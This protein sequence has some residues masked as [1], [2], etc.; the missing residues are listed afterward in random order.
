MRDFAWST[1]GGLLIDDT[2]DIAFSISD[3]DCL[4]DMINTRLKTTLDGWKLYSIGANLQSV[5]GLT[6]NQDLEDQIKKLVQI[7]LTNQF[8]PLG[9]FTVSTIIIGNIIKV[10]VF[11]QNTL[12]TSYS[13]VL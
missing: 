8:L 10:Y 13:V 5:I 2:G 7:S 6:E 3:W 1:S 11:I 9:S 4:R 12:V